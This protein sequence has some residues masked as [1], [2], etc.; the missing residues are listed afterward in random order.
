M[1]T[2]AKVPQGPP[3][4]TIFLLDDS[5][6]ER[7]Y[8]FAVTVGKRRQEVD[9]EKGCTDRLFS[10][11]YTSEEVSVRGCL[12]EAAFLR[13]MGLSM[14]IMYNTEVNSVATD[15]GDAVIPLTGESF[16]VKTTNPGAPGV[17]AM[18]HKSEDS[19]AKFP[20]T[21]YALMSILDDDPEERSAMLRFDGVARADRVIR[22]ENFKPWLGGNKGGYLL[23]RSALRTL[24]DERATFDAPDHTSVFVWDM[25]PTHKM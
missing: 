19:K 20:I 12:G 18:A 17:L 14:A 15:R 1:S 2:M 22:D 10:K 3:L 13:M 6:K 11:K 5:T 23:P 7:L 21:Y 8:T 16:D 25:R 24:A 9:R 4:G